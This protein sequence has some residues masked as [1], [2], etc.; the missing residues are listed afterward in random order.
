MSILDKAI[1]RINVT[2]IKIPIAFFTEIEKNP[3]IH[4]KS[5]KTLSS[6]LEKEEQSWRLHT[7]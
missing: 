6:S 4:I 3:K 5:Q 7:S 1:Y 2:P